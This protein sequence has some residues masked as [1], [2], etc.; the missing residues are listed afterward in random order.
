MIIIVTHEGRGWFDPLV[1]GAKGDVIALA[2]YVL[3]CNVGHAC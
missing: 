2:K 1:D 3:L